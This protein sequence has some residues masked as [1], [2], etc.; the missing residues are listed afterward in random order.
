MAKL[1]KPLDI[2]LPQADINLGGSVGLSGTL[3]LAGTV[4]LTPATIKTLT[5]GKV[6]PSEP[7]PIALGLGG[8]AWAP[9]ITGLD[10]RPAALGI[11]KA[12]GAS[13]LKGV[14]GDS[15][16]GKAAGGILGGVLGGGSGTGGSE[17]QQPATQ[18]EQ[19]A[20]SDA[21]KMRQQ[22]A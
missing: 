8:P 6:T 1:T 7:I 19:K 17:Q 18:G 10:I 22:A 13:A 12:A 16:I 2:K 11:A 5:G 21:E 14:L 9:Q 15:D 3:A 4:A 20:Q